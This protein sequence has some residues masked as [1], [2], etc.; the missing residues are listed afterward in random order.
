MTAPDMPRPPAQQHDEPGVPGAGRW[1]IVGG[2][3][4]LALP[5]TGAFYFFAVVAALGCLIDCS[6]SDPRPVLA[7]GLL[8]GAAVMAGAWSGLVPWAM[9]RRELV[10]RTAVGGGLLVVAVF[11][12]TLLVG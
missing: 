2:L 5:V 1:L 10:L 7:G 12:V 11:A 4:L 3:L 6:Q 9:G 8:L